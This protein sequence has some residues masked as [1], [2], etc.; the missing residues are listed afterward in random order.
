MLPTLFLSHGS[1]ML[2]LED[3]PARRFLLGLGASFA[4][5]Q[6]IV[7]VSAHWET[8]GS[9]AAGLT[10]APET[11]HDF[12]GF[13]PALHALSYAA[14]GAPQ[15]A[16]S[17]IKLLEAEG[18]AA[19]GNAR[20]GLDHGAWVPLSLMYPQADIPVCQLSL[21]RGADA[22]A[23]FRMGCALQSLREQGVLVL[24]SGSMTHNLY[25]A[26]G[27]ASD[28]RELPWARE[29][30]E[31]MAAALL[32]GRSDDLL[33]YRQ[34]APFALRNHPSEEHLLPLFVALGAAGDNATA[35]RLHASSAHGVLAMDSYRFDA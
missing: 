11:I 15:A 1:P 3:S 9:V 26:M 32:A 20:R 4:R 25:E 5:P 13:P 21:L 23:H 17:C 6:A 34:R 30:A 7:V 18:F 10:E 28:A 12:A 27:Y 19:S 16:Q 24:G 33:N 22:A 8:L 31:W 35:H 29:F 2:A 14:P